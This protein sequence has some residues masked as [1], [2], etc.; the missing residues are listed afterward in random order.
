MK[1]Y[2]LSFGIALLLCVW[3]GSVWAADFYVA[4]DG[5]DLHSGMQAAE[6]N[7]AGPCAS[8]DRA[9]KAAR[10]L[11]RQRPNRDT[12]IVIQVRGG[13]YY[14]ESTLRLTADDSGT[15]QSP[16]VIEA[17]L[18]ETPIISGGRLLEGRS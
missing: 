7:G 14:L 10:R 17:Y 2:T 18:N 4:P 8:L 13:T 12:P 11:R 5:E 1:F 9:A 15:S 6:A 16:L 3:P